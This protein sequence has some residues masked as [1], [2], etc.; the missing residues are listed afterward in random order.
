MRNADTDPRISLTLEEK[1]GSEITSRIRNTVAKTP[2]N[3]NN[4]TLYAKDN[5]KG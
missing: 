4:S 1:F 2:N 3:Q 5:K